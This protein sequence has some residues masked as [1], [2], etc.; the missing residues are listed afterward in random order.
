MSTIKTETIVKCE[1]NEVLIP[2][3]DILAMA[4]LIEKALENSLERAKI[5]RGDFS[6]LEE[7]YHKGYRHGFL[8]T[9]LKGCQER[10]RREYQ[11]NI[12]QTAIVGIRQKM[13][14]ETIAKITDLSLDKLEQLAANL[15]E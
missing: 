6:K 4:E 2:D 14:L 12:L 10:Y 1:E 11:R 3:K 9:Y 8:E 15:K 7:Y 5:R 13:P